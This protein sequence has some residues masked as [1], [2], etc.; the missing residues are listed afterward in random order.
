[1]RLVRWQRRATLP[2]LLLMLVLATAAAACGGGDEATTG[3]TQAAATTAG[4][5]E[6]PGGDVVFVEAIAGVTNNFDPNIWLG[7]ES[8]QTED[9]LGNQTADL[10]QYKHKP[11]SLTKLAGVTEVEPALAESY[12]RNEDGSYTMTLRDA[13]S[14]YGNTITSEDVKWSL[15]RAATGPIGEFLMNV[16]SI[17]KDNPVEIIDDKSFTLRVTAPNSLTLAVLTGHFMQIFDSVEVKKH[18]TADDPWAGK[19][20]TSHSANFG[21]WNIESFTPGQEVRFTANP[22]WWAGE[23]QIKTVVIRSVPDS[24]TRLQ[25]I[26]SGEVDFSLENS[27]Q[28]FKSVQGEAGL[29]PV[30]AFLAAKDTLSLDY[31]YT[32]PDDRK[33]FADP[34]VRKAISMAIDREALVEGAYAGFGKPALYQMASNIPRPSL[35][36]PEKYDPEAAKALL[37]EAGYGDGFAFTLTICPCRPGPHSQDIAV[38]LKSQLEENLNL[39]IEIETIASSADYQGAIDEDRI[40]AFLYNDQV[41][42]NDPGYYMWLWDKSDG[43]QNYKGYNNPRV[44]ELIELILT[45]EPGEQRDAYVV[46]AE[47]ILNDETPWI[48]LV[49]APVRMI[50]RDNI[51]ISNLQFY[52]QFSMHPEDL[53]KR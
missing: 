26:K 52:P 45:T 41:D 27:F 47:Q 1:M 22:N 18:V 49:E 46:E 44:D 31:R 12:E 6:A 37:A 16:G 29:Q 21:P 42:V 39:D 9:F 30:E 50:F 28:E 8:V 4:G 53:I 33:P 10:V 2:G 15:E 36:E 48:S 14:S 40:H 20:L 38:F 43:F 3:P 19:W 51:D 17:D 32:L 11:D 13:Q 5:E 23:S 34:R 24:S 35:P 7:P 25:L